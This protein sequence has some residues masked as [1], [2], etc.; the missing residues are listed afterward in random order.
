MHPG[1][2]TQSPFTETTT[3]A[4]V[5]ADPTKYGAPTPEEFMRN[6]EKYTVRK[7]H[8]LAAADDGSKLEGLKR[9]LGT[10]YWEIDGYR[11]D[12]PEQI[13]RYCKDEGLNPG[14]DLDFRPYLIEG[15]SGKIDVVNRFH[16][17]KKIE[18]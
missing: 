10:T 11:M 2:E 13:E 9:R 16:R 7:D 3:L 14:T 15:V 5:A 1:T 12:T 18:G 8:L 6:R 17:K 4:E